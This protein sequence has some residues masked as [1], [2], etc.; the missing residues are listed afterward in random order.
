M[1]TALI[2]EDDRD[3]AEVAAQLLRMRDLRPIIAGTGAEGLA[4]AAAQPLEVILLDLMLPDL[5][6]LEVCRRLRARPET[7]MIPIIM[8]TALGGGENRLRGFWCGATGY[9]TKPY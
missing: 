3:Q 4:Q 5:H 1:D 7:R 9:V 2:I 6:G 8:L